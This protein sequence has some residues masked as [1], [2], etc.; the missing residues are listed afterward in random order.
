MDLVVNERK[1]NV[2]DSLFR[3]AYKS[4]LAVASVPGRG[5]DI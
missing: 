4:R 1:A 2:P 5:Y 3:R